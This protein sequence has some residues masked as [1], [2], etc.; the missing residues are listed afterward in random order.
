MRKILFGITFLL[1]VVTVCAQ[2]YNNEWINF[3]QT[4]YKFKVGGNGLYRISQPVLSSIG[5][6][7]TSADQF[8]LWRNGK[9]IAIYTTIPTGVFGVL[10]YI[11]F[12]GQFNDGKADKQLYKYDGLQMSDKLSM[13]TDTAA[14]FLTVNSAVNKRFTNI[15]NDVPGNVLP[16]ETGF[17]HSLQKSYKVKIGRAH[18]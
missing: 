9:E 10:D 1:S 13:L 18:V 11:E 8:Q 17:I 2:T 5:L 4:Y 14:Y 3:S 16:P 6:A 15:S 7:G 12:Y